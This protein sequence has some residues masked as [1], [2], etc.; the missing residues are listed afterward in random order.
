MKSL[1]MDQ[2]FMRLLALFKN[3]K[4]IRKGRN[5]SEGY[6]RGWGLQFGNLRKMISED[7]IY[8]KAFNLCAGRSI[9]AEDNLMNIFLILKYFLGNVPTGDIV[10]FGAYR[11]GSA[12]FIASIV[13]QLYPGIRVYALDTFSGMPKTDP[14]IDV[15]TEGNF[16]DVNL[17][18]LIQYTIDHQ[19]NNIEFIPGLFEETVPCL[20][21]KTNGVALVH[22]DCDIYSA[23]AYSYDAVKPC[24]VQGG[25]FVFD[26]A[27]YSSCMGATEAVEDLVIRRDGFN[28]EQIFPQ[29]VFRHQ[30]K[31]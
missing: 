6:A 2:E 9:V 11:G 13:K 31:P 18:E 25:Y 27:N 19:L 24:M 14:N 21:S 4:N 22:I 15:H 28:S 16:S 20:L 17:K 10:E 1:K 23:V 12:I 26:D 8:K 3:S 5:V 29:Y 7:F 30:V